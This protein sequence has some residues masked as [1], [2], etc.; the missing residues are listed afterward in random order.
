MDTIQLAIADPG[1]ATALR[2]SLMRDAAWSVFSVDLPDPHVQ[3]V[4]VVDAQ[5]RG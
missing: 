2:E 1:Y 4:I 5:A 3:G